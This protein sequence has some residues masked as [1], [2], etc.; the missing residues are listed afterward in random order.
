MAQPKGVPGG[1]WAQHAQHGVRREIREG[2]WPALLARAAGDG[3]I[4]ASVC[5]GAMLLAHAGVIGSRRASTHHSARAE[6][7]GLGATVVEDRVVDQGSLITAGG[8]TSGL[9]LGLWLVERFAG[10]A[11][12]DEIAGRLEYARYRPAPG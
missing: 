7:A 10:R 3:A 8:V 4:T 9:D 6:L 5:T 1:G 11:L 12:A 2:A